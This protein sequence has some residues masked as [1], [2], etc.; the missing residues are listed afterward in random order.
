MSLI[1]TTVPA[2]RAN[3]F[4]HRGSQGEFIEITEQ[5]LIGRFARNRSFLTCIDQEVGLRTLD[6]DE[7]AQSV[8]GHEQIFTNEVA[9]LDGSARIV[10]DGIGTELIEGS[11]KWNEYGVVARNLEPGVGTLR[12]VVRDEISRHRS[13]CG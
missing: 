1:N 6:V 12:L 5:T 8:W 13:W 9:Q 3:A 10:R 2:F 11:A 7:S 4:V